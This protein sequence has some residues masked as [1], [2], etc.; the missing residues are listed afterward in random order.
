MQNLGFALITPLWMYL[1]LTYS[2]TA[3]ADPSSVSPFTSSKP[4]PLLTLPFS[5]F[6]AFVVPNVLMSLSPPH[7]LSP[8]TST[9]QFYTALSQFWPLYLTASQIILPIV[10][11][12]AKPGINA[13]SEHDKKRN[14]LKYLR[15]CYVFALLTATSSHLIAL[16]IPLLA[17][18]FPELFS[19]AYVAQVQPSNV[20]VSVSPLPPVRQIE[21]VAEGALRLIQWDLYIGPFTVLVWAVALRV[22]AQGRGFWLY[23]WMGGLLKVGALTAVSGP[24][25]AAV[26]V[27]WERDELVF[28]RDLGKDREKKRT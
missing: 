27:M 11:S 16:G 5:A 6:L 25:G 28:E 18:L 14:S 20:F 22:Q 15:R 19:S 3:T 13:L 24:C 9:K 21:D 17:Y 8:T 4:L 1:H 7:P 10:I 26:A 23:E 12:A 2:A